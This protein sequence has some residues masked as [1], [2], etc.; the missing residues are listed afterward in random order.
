MG[1]AIFGGGGVGTYLGSILLSIVEYQTLF[2]IYI[3]F[4]FIPLL[5]MLKNRDI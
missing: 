5:I 3:C 2:L 4:A 1:V